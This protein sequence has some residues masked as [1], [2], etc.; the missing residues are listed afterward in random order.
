MILKFN[1]RCKERRAVSNFVAFLFVLTMI[2]PSYG[3]VA[4]DVPADVILKQGQS[5]VSLSEALSQ[6]R[7][8]TVVVLGE[9]HGTMELATQQLQ[10]I[11]NIKKNGRVVSVGFEFFE[12]QYQD[13][14]DR[15]RGFEISEDDFLKGIRWGAGFSFSAYRQQALAPQLNLG[16]QTI[17]LNAKRTLTAKIASQG[18]ASL[19]EQER[20]ELPEGF[21]L[22]NQRYFSRFKSIMQDH[23]PN[24]E[25]IDR[26]FAAQSVWDDTMAFHANQFLAAHP[27]QVLVIIVGEFH[28]QYGG[29]LPDRLRARGLSVTTFS[30]LNLQGLD[31]EEQKNAVEPS[32]EYGSRADFVWTSRFGLPSFTMF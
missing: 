31:S 4:Q 11:E 27:E 7:P 24:P 25:A 10:I 29:G 23:L 8:G 3:A 32:A 21:S 16:E 28:V 30:L 14:V 1:C 17:A 13:L 12:A 19:N 22:G 18:L 6:V 9:Q 26:Y 2:L 5:L 20:G 15:W